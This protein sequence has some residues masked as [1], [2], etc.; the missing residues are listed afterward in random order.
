MPTRTGANEA[1]EDGEAVPSRFH[2]S[3]PALAFE[4][5]YSFT[6][7]LLSRVASGM[8]GGVSVRGW[9]REHRVA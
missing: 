1:D 5:N 7:I 4:G 2:G 8:V 9:N 6:L 3:G